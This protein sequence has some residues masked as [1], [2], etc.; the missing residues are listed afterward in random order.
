MA[1]KKMCVFG[2][3]LISFLLP[4]MKK[5]VFT[6][7]NLCKAE[8]KLISLIFLKKRKNIQNPLLFTFLMSLTF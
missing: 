7:P 4:F 5:F 6:R 8:Y 2:L 3:L 1:E